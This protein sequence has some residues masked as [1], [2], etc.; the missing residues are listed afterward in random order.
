MLDLL[1]IERTAPHVLLISFNNRGKISA[2]F[3]KLAPFWSQA[4]WPTGLIR[5]IVGDTLCVLLLDS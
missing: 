3:Q 2:E 4:G 5:F 1:L